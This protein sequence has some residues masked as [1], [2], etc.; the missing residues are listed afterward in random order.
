VEIL[1]KGFLASI[2]ITLMVVSPA[3]S[4][5]MRQGRPDGGFG[6][7]GGPGRA[8]SATLERAG[9]KLGQ[10]LPDFAVHDAQGDVFR[11]ADLKGKHSVIIFGCLT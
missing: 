4:Q 6:G 8:G 9:L 11:L 1:M 10:P 5:R 2:A 7:R 3:L